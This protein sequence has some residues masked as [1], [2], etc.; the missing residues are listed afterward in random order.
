MTEYLFDAR[1]LIKTYPGEARPALADVSLT[2]RPGEFLAVTGPSG[3]GKSTLLNVLSVLARPD[4]GSILYK[5]AD[6]VTATE[7]ERNRLRGA[8]FAFIFQQHHLMPYLNALE[9][10]LLPLMN[11]LAPISAEWKKKGQ[12]VLERVGL[13]HKAASR[14]GELSGGEQQ[15]VAIA[16]ALARNVNVL[17]ADEPTGSLDSETGASVMA[18]LRELNR[19]GL[20]VI[21]ITH[22]QD[23]ALLADRMLRMKD[24]VILDD[25]AGLQ[26][27][28]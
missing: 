9:N 26:P 23:Y 1:G 25:G 7:A 14:P 8:E 22:N 21:M 12:D 24:G 18:L 5:G 3:S 2:I 6:I 13:G 4:A 16:R 19:N 11:R 10:T 20:T 15:R 27:P 28:A 17:F